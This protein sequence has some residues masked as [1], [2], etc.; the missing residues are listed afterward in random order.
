MAYYD[1]NGNTLSIDLESSSKIITGYCS[2]VY[3]NNDTIF[4]EYY[5]N[6]RKELRLSVEAFN[7][8]KNINNPHFIELYD[9]YC[10][11]DFY[12]TL[13]YMLRE[14]LFKVDGYTAKYYSDNSV[15]VLLEHK[16]YLLDN[17]RELEELFNYFSMHKVYLDDVRRANTILGKNCIVIIDPD[18]FVL[19]CCSNI[20]ALNGK[21]SNISLENKK[22]LLSL[23]NDL[24]TSGVDEISC[25]INSLRADSFFNF[26]V[27]D[28]TNITD[29]VAKRLK[30]V[31][32]PIDYVVK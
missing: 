3:H 32:K 31:K 27:D 16:D 19:G 18:L 6:I 12:E 22:K 21:S 26:K 17:L 25:C 11:Y 30:Y 7:F 4:K 28:R 14:R 1:Q 29:E 23:V 2:V 15:N 20:S 5:P 24:F 8:F 13:S 9:M 10:N